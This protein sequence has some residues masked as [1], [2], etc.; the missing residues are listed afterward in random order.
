MW[1]LLVDPGRYT[2]RAIDEG[3]CRADCVVQLTGNRWKYH[4]ENFTEIDYSPALWNRYLGLLRFVTDMDSSSLPGRVSWVENIKWNLTVS[5]VYVNNKGRVIIPLFE[6][7][8]VCYEK[9]LEWAAIVEVS[10][11]RS[12]GRVGGGSRRTWCSA[13]RTKDFKLWSQIM[14]IKKKKLI[15]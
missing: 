1:V 3:P 10:Y 4:S 13:L 15:F 6:Y 5:P 9:P 11:L 14:L 12:V 2:I 8:S 7:I